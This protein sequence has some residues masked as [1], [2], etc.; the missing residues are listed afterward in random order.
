MRVCRYSTGESLELLHGSPLGKGGEARV[1]AVAGN[2]NLAAKIYHT[3][4]PQHVCKVM[5]M[6]KNPCLVSS[7]TNGSQSLA[8]PTDVLV[9]DK[10]FVG[11]LMPRVQHMQPVMNV[12]SP[13]IRRQ[14]NLVLDYRYLHRIGSNVSAVVHAVH[15]K[16]YCIG[17]VNESNILVSNTALALWVDTDSFQIRD[18]HSG[19][20]YHC[21]VGKPDFT[22]P[23]LQ[24]KNLSRVDRF[25]EQDL[26]GLSVI[27]FRLLMEGTHPF[28]AVFTSH[29]EPPP[30]ESR[31]AAGH[32]PHGTKTVPWKPKP[33]APPFRILH[34]Q[35]RQ[36]F[37]QCFQ[38]GHNNPSMRPTAQVWQRALLDAER[39]LVQCQRHPQHWYGN[40]LAACPWCERAKYLGGIDPFPHPNPLLRHQPK[41]YGSRKRSFQRQ[42]RLTAVMHKNSFIGHARAA[43]SILEQVFRNVAHEVKKRFPTLII[44]VGGVE[45]LATHMGDVL[46]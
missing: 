20:I 3:P 8:W 34:P 11:F 35:L 40:Y 43:I 31:I 30:L 14:K 9:R 4:S 13:K 32:F 6:L 37:V 33:L 5:T 26:F 38:D 17:D 27:I 45:M 25:A 22:P 24:G 1:L 7:A 19:E 46:L 21:N 36:L 39:Q 18:P 42:K 41:L 10:G 16:G 2:S 23:E 28:D 29:G 12:Y 15:K 44:A